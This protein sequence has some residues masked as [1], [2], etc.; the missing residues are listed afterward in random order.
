MGSS[1]SG[2]Q[3]LRLETVTSENNISCPG[4]CTSQEWVS[5]TVYQC[6]TVAVD[7]TQVS[8]DLVPRP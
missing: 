6:Q 4:A 1:R 7:E 3:A 5:L 8:F 2:A